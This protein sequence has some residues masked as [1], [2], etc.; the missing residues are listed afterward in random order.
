MSRKFGE[1]VELRRTREKI[2]DIT[3]TILERAL[4]KAEKHV[5]SGDDVYISTDE[6]GRIKLTARKNK[7]Q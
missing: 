3:E 4:E 6:N 7:K 1:D 5:L 2:F